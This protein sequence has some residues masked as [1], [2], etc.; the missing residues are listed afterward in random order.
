MTN[1]QHLIRFSKIWNWVIWVKVPLQ[2]TTQKARYVRFWNKVWGA[3]ISQ[4]E[5][6]APL[7]FILV[8]RRQ[9]NKQTLNLPTYCA[10]IKRL[11]LGNISRPIIKWKSQI[12][13]R[14]AERPKPAVTAWFAPSAAISP[15][16]TI[17]AATV[18]AYLSALQRFDDAF[19]MGRENKNE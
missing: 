8:N 18:I 19:G 7:W 11:M 4:S 5:R 1:Q 9:W 12:Q 16:H 14:P 17:R 13:L 3:P 10:S 6:Q 2:F 15:R